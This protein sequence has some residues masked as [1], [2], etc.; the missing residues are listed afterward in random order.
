MRERGYV[1]PVQVIWV[2]VPIHMRYGVASSPAHL[3]SRIFIFFFVRRLQGGYLEPLYAC[4]APAAHPRRHCS[5]TNS[6]VGVVRHPDP[7]PEGVTC[8]QHKLN[9]GWDT[10]RSSLFQVPG[11]LLRSGC[12]NT[13]AYEK[14]CTRNHTVDLRHLILLWTPASMACISFRA[15]HGSISAWALPSPVRECC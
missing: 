13:G 6:P 12:R 5:A 4:I 8:K 14:P 15:R 10:L 11:D 3:P 7:R 9:S 1:Q 2:L